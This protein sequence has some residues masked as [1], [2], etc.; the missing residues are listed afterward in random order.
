MWLV[1][2]GMLVAAFSLYPQLPERVPVH[3]NLEGEVDRYGSRLEA[4]FEIP[5]LTLGLYLLMLVTPLIDPNRRNYGRF[6]G[7]YR[8][9]RW[10]FVFFMVVVYGIVMTSAL[11][12]AVDVGRWVE[13]VLSL[14]FVV[15]GNVMGQIKPNYFVGIRTPW[16]LADEEVWRR[17]HRLAARVWVFGGLICLLLSFVPGR[18]AAIAFVVGIVS[19]GLIPIVASY[20]YFSFRE[21]DGDEGKK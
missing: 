17:T 12:H 16:T 20:V 15:T 10:S 5:L 11:G 9:I 3:W 19:M 4:A 7:A 1:L 6:L 13:V 2:V 18:A 8:V 21:A 14:I